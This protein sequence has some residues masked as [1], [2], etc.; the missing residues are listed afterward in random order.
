[1]GTFYGYTRV[2][3]KGQHPERGEYEIREFCKENNFP[4]KKVYIDIITGTTFDRPWYKILKEDVLRKGD[5]LIITEVDR[6][7]RNKKEIVKELMYFRE[8]GIRVIFLELPMTLNDLKEKF[9][10]DKSSGLM[11]E[12]ITEFLIILYASLA[13]AENHKRKKRQQEGYDRLRREGKWDIL[14]RPRVMKEEIFAQHY[15]KVLSGE[16]RPF[17]LIKEIG[18]KKSTYYQYKRDYDIKH[19]DN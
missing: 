8:E 17:D 7:G 11:Y 10:T 5:T 18:M 1:M 12:T 2:S 14:G 16:I 6:L 4:L 9:G 13:E 3:S 15:K 19:K